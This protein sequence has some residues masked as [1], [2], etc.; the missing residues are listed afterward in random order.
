MTTKDGA[1]SFLFW[2]MP[3]FHVTPSISLRHYSIDVVS[4]KQMIGPYDPWLIGR[5]YELFSNIDRP[6]WKVLKAC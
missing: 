6:F 1:E 4:R 3:N 5:A 2:E